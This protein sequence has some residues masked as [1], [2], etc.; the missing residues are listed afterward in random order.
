ME[1]INAANIPAVVPPRTRTN[2]NTAIV[3][4]EP[5]ATGKYIVKSYNDEP[6]PNNFEREPLKEKTIFLFFVIAF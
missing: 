3:V 1:K 4:S 6:K 2:A 5:I